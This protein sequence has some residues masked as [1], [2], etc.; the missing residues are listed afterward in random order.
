MLTAASSSRRNLWRDFR[1][2][3]SVAIRY[4]TQDTL[5]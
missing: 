5:A 3:R 4:F 1:L 2:Y